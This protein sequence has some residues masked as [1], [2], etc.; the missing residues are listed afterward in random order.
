MPERVTLVG[1]EQPVLDVPLP[2]EPEGRSLA[3]EISPGPGGDRVLAAVANARADGRQVVAKYRTGGTSA[4]AF[5]SESLLAEVICAAADEPVPLK[6]T[7]GLHHAVRCTDPT[8]GFEHHGFLNVMIAVARAGTGA[9]PQ[10]VSEVLAVRSGQR[11]AAA[12]GD[13]ADRQVS[14]LRRA[15]VS[16]GCCGVEDPI[17]DLVEL[18]L[19]DPEETP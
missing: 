11:L 15:F 6:L 7:A 13:L 19:L 1:F 4:D 12:V 8:T 9:G 10:A 14:D 18:G 16:F 2:L 17:G 5:P 3:V